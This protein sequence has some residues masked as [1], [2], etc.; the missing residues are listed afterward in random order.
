MRIQLNKIDHLSKQYDVI[1]KN[2]LKFGYD[3]KTEDLDFSE[4][5]RSSCDLL[6]SNK[7]GWWH[8]KIEEGLVAYVCPTCNTEM[9]GC[10]QYISSDEYYSIRV[11]ERDFDETTA[12]ASEIADAFSAYKYQM[13]VI[14][15]EI[16]QIQQMEKCPFCGKVLSHEKG[17]YIEVSDMLRS[18]NC[19]RGKKIINI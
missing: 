10:W 6:K 16:G 7:S 1:K 3:I 14:E 2:L 12:K 17:Y 18:F 5:D 15:P 9:F 8:W 13:E 19:L 4:S 11:L